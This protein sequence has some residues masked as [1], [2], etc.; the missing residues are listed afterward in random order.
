MK[1]KTKKLTTK[2]YGVLEISLNIKKL[3]LIFKI[4]IFKIDHHQLQFFILY[5]LTILKIIVKI[6]N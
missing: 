2:I 3:F 5:I 1:L 4:K 6:N